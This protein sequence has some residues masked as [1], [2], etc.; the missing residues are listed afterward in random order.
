ME[1]R[2]L[3][4]WNPYKTKLT[5]IEKSK[6]KKIVLS[7]SQQFRIRIHPPVYELCFEADQISLSDSTTYIFAE[8]I[9]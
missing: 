4:L 8:L 9:V 7:I 6:Y 2:H 5:S 1:R 3:V